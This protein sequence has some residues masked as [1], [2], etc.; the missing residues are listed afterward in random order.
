MKVSTIVGFVAALVL[1]VAPSPSAAQTKL[2]V[3]KA[4]GVRIVRGERGTIVFVFTHRAAKLS[5]RIAGRVVTIDCPV[6]EPRERPPRA[7][8]GGLDPLSGA[9]GSG[10]PVTIR[11]PKHGRKLVGHDLPRGDYCRVWLTPIGRHG[12]RDRS[13][14]VLSVPLTRTGAVFLDEESKARQLVG[15]LLGVLLVGE[16]RQLSGWPTYELL[17]DWGARKAGERFVGLDGPT[18]TPPAGAIGYWSDGH[19]HVAVVI[20]SRSGR[21]LFIEFADDVVSTNVTGYIFDWRPLPTP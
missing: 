19:F 15:V 2:P 14:L 20:L 12:G 9:G 21:R 7:G 6:L 18:D 10:G 5:K 1:L 11:A 4:H 13:R 16:R 3:G 8:T 17:L